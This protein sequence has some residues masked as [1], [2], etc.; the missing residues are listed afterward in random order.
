MARSANLTHLLFF[1][2]LYGAAGPNLLAQGKGDAASPVPAI[3]MP[4]GDDTT[5]VKEA[6]AKVYAAYSA[7]DVQKYQALLTGDYLLLENG[8]LLD[9][10]GDAAMMP[11]PGSGYQRTDVFG[12]RSVKVHD[13]IAYTVYFLK[14]EIRDR[15]GSRNR[16]WLESA[17]F[18]RSGTGWRM[19]LLHSTRIHKSGD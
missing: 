16:Q 5:A 19:A 6:V 15:N 11:A 17:I 2:I 10:E 18:R 8:E 4:S 3:G 12:F 14:S 7:F 13:D 1:I 9:S